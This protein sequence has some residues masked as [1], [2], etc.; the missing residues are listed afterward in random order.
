MYGPISGD[1]VNASM[2]DRRRQAARIA[3]ENAAGH[4][5][6]SAPSLRSKLAVWFALYRRAGRTV[7]TSPF[8]S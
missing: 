1:L 5:L 2:E 3:L 4:S 8:A 6:N 7:A